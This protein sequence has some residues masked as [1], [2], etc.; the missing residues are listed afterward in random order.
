[1]ELSSETAPPT[2]SVYVLSDIDGYKY[3][4]VMQGDVELLSVR[5]VKR[6]LQRAAGIHPAQQLLSFN[7]VELNDTMSG[8]DAGFFDGAIL[9]LQQV[10][11]Y[12]AGRA[13]CTSASG[14]SP[15]L[16]AHKGPGS[17]SSN[18]VSFRTQ[19]NDS[20]TSPRKGDFVVD[21]TSALI[22]APAVRATIHTQQV[23]SSTPRALPP[24][25]RCL[26]P[27]QSTGFAEREAHDAASCAKRDTV[28][29]IVYPSQAERRSAC[30]ATVGTLPTT[31]WGT[32][33]A[34]N[35]NWDGAHA[36]CQE[37]EGKVAA[38]SIDNVR[39]REQLQAAA[40]QAAESCT[41]WKY[42]EEVKQLKATVAMAQQG[43]RDAERA[44]AHRWRVKE[45]ELV[46]ELD[47]LREERRRFQEE[48]TTQEA[49]LQGL[50]HSMEG[51]IRGLKYELHDKDEALQTARLSLAE[52]QRQTSSWPDVARC[53]SDSVSG[54][55]ID[56][57]FAPAA[58]PH[59]R[60]PLHQRQHGGSSSI[61]GLAEAA[62]EC[63]AQTFESA[64]PLKLDPDNDTCV[65]PVANGLNVLV[66]LD[67][68]TERLF[69]YV[70]LLN[71]LPSSLVQRMQL[72][73][74]LLEGALLGKDM[75]GGGVGVSLEANLVLMS[76]SANLRHSAASALAVTA[77]PFVEAAQ[78]LTTR[79]DALLSTRRVF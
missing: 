9:R 2:T 38:L 33:S 46:K 58:S 29:D 30:S 63:L 11:P 4:L 10:S 75:A 1:M 47:L 34:V 54:S 24:P 62:L 12:S 55:R 45:E 16:S 13:T 42:E 32:S 21:G 39:L 57:P 8:K 48:S 72:Y 19:D 28:A 65:I 52:L 40:R 23:V 14:A 67:R 56:H 35:A 76:V 73:E 26:S 50:M 64:A 15:R 79:I 60:I 49:K 5:K 51:E 25:L 31:S 78:A 41:D 44:A 3:K 27:N 71:R 59:A 66:T 22:S 36:Y 61:D 74:M 6:Y 7:S 17:A 37:L 43:A 20:R 70:P 77:T 69:L 68:E 53:G 18:T